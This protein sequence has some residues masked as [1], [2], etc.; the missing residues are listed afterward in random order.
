MVRF[1]DNFSGG[2][3]GAVTA[4]LLVEEGYAVIFMHRRR[5]TL[6]YLRWV[7]EESAM[8]QLE[9]SED[10]KSVVLHN[11]KAAAAIAAM[12]KAALVSVAFVSVSDYLHLFRALCCLLDTPR[13]LIYACA[14]V[15]DF[16]IPAARMTQHKIQSRGAVSGLT[17]QLDN[18]PKLLGELRGRW[19]PRAVIVTFKLET[20]EAIL[21]SKASGSLASYRQDMVICNLLSSY[22]HRVVLKYADGRNV[23]V[24]SEGVVEE[25]FVPLIVAF[26]ATKLIT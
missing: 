1:I 10:G 17:L 23:E 19:C 8:A 15:S 20:D 12:H 9:V 24:T 5:S 18:V 21:D 4:E 14:A 13:A 3:R 16:F 2:M 22:R 25:K 7:Q 11:S 26:H 6:P